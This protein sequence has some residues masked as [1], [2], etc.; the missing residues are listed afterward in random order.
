MKIYYQ[1]LL[2]SLIPFLAHAQGPVGPISPQSV[3][4]APEKPAIDLPY[5]PE[6]DEP[7]PLMAPKQNPVSPPIV[8]PYLRSKSPEL[9][10]APDPII[11]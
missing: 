5:K 8:M 3:P 1:I 7:K 2:L 11:N 6:A 9:E 10:K 4:S